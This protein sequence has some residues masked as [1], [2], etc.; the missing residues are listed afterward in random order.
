MANVEE[1]LVNEH[2]PSLL[3]RRSAK[4]DSLLLAHRPDVPRPADG[5]V[6]SVPVADHRLRHR[7]AGH[8]HGNAM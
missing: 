6:I 1:R 5:Y 4:S 3:V 8:G 2:G 7:Y